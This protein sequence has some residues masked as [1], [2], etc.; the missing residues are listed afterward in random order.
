MTDPI[1]AR[2]DQALGATHTIERELGGGGMAR[3]FLATERA[4]GRQVVIKT[5]PDESWSGDA[6]ARFRREILTAAQLQHANIVPVLTAGD[7]DGLPFFTMPWVEGASLRERIQRGRVPLGEATSILRDV[8]RALAAAHARGIV[9]RDIKPENILLSSGAALVTDF[10]VAKALTLATQG[11]PGA[12][13]MTGIGV[14]IGTLAY[15]APEQIAGEATL[16]QRADL[17][18]WGMLAYE[19]LSGARPFATLSGSALTRAQ[20]TELP[21][22]LAEVAPEVSP[23]L[24]AIVMR[25]LAKTADERPTNAAELLTVLDTPSGE[26]IGARRPTPRRPWIAATLIAVAAVIAIVVGALSGRDDVDERTIAVAPFRVGGAAPE[27]QYLREGLGDLIVPM[28]AALP[29]LASANMRVVLDRW[30]RAAGS[31]DEDLDDEAASRVAREAGAGRLIIGDIVGTRERLTVS[32]RLLRSRDGEELATAQISGSADSASALAIRVVTAL[33]SVQDGPPRERLASVLSS[34]VEAIAPYLRGEQLYRRGRYRAAAEEFERAWRADSTLAIAAVRIRIANSWNSAD[35]IPGPWVQRAWNHRDR[36]TGSDSLLL[37]AIAGDSFP[38][39]MRWRDRLTMLR[40]LAV[41]GNTAELW[42]QYGDAMVHNGNSSDVDSAWHYA[43]QAFKR[44]EAMDSSLTSALEHQSQ[45]YIALGDS[46]GARAALARQARV[47][48][49]GDWYLV[50][51]MF[52]EAAI[53]D[54][55]D[56]MVALR[57]LTARRPAAILPAMRFVTVDMGPGIPPN[58]E[59]IDSIAAMAATLPLDDRTRTQLE[60]ALNDVGIA[61][62]QSRLQRVTP[63]MRAQIADGIDVLLYAVVNQ[64]ASDSAAAARTSAERLARREMAR[65]PADGKYL[66]APMFSLIG[67]YDALAGDT[68]SAL[69]LAREIERLSFTPDRPWNADPLRI[70]AEMLRLLVAAERRDPNLLRLVQHADSTLADIPNL[71]AAVRAVWNY[72]IAV[73]YERM[74]R[75]ADAYRMLQRRDGQYTFEPALLEALRRSARNAERA[76][77]RE[78]AIFA[79]RSLIGMRAQADSQYQGEVQELRAR[80]ARLEAESRGR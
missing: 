18:A 52:V 24:A 5:L 75:P 46:A 29:D 22:P 6:G 36:L 14:T 19:L 8:A 49:A 62:G 23:A 39:P 41:Q 70:N 2:L 55:A 72:L 51:R 60:F 7:A 59:L 48:S 65:M 77:M 37:I 34:K 30:R 31:V 38:K 47:D 13:T 44:A 27:T 28:V 67:T 56:Q 32:A 3:V 43:L 21:P 66:I 78:Q 71:D 79:L 50:S 1:R 64:T 20:L 42:Y 68:A 73:I 15:M 53:G 4:L 33:L 26:F 12:P 74:D 35:A 76:G 9:H 25:C 10:G 45:A 69:S 63:Q 57:A 40:N 61:T 17:Y 16:D 80:L 58:L 54:I 11:G